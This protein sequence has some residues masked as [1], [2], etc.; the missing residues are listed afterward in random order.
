[1]RWLASLVVLVACGGDDGDILDELAALPNVR[2]SEWTQPQGFE[3]EPGYRY[4]DL[5]FT[6]P[7]D[8]ENLA[9]GTITG[10]VRDTSGAVLPGVAVEASSA[11][12][13]ERGRRV[14]TDGEGV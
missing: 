13:I 5:W 2:V 4:F 12:L 1:M 7:V 9:A 8:H 6:Q 14:V 10:V 3:P 11:A